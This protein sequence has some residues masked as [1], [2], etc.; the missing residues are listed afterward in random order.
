MGSVFAG[1]TPAQCRQIDALA[2]SIRVPAGRTLTEQGTTGREF[3]VLLDGSATVTI[4]GHEVARLGPG[5]HFGELALLQVVGRRAATIVADCD[6]R[7]AVMSMQEFATL[8]ADFDDVGEL[9]ERNSEKYAQ[10][11]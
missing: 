8:V 1:Y 2:T 6:L 4:D 10:T 3:G 9:L 11:C 7:V 5:D